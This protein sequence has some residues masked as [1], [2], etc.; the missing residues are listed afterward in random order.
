MAPTSDFELAAIQSVKELRDIIQ[1]MMALAT[2]DQCDEDGVL[3]PTRFALDRTNE[4][5]LDAC[6]FLLQESIR[7]GLPFHFPK[8]SLSTDTG[9]GTRIEWHKPQ[10]SVR[11]VIPADRDGKEY[12]YHEMGDDFGSDRQ[13]TGGVLARWL[14]R[15]G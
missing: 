3:R 13:V 10:A 9:G 15:L 2:G 1:Q 11:L 14:K 5:L 12:V 6:G 7:L 8:G 4:L